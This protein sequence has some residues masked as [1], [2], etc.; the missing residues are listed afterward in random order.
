MDQEVN[1]ATWLGVTLTLIVTL[2]VA[3][4]ITMQIGRGA[5]NKATDGIA[6]YLGLKGGSL[7]V[8]EDTIT[9][10]SAASAQLMI[11]ENREYIVFEESKMS[12]KL[13]GDANVTNLSE[14]SSV[15]HGDV[16]LEIGRVV[17]GRYK[18]IVHRYDCAIKN[19]GGTC[20]CSPAK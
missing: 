15:A 17:Q 7:K 8:M 3:V 19:F 2:M 12:N 14:I 5:A 10:M 9:P 1:K 4:A 20:N 6:L 13:Y 16:I 18:V 11:L